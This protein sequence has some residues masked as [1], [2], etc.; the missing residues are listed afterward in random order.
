M[1]RVLIAGSQRFIVFVYAGFILQHG[2]SP[3]LWAAKA[4]HLKLVEIL[5]A[6]GE[7]LWPLVTSVAYDIGC[8]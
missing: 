1:N 2:D 6:A 7:G 3:L 5:L 4:G 8:L